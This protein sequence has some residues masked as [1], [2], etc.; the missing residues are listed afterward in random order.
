MAKTR[1]DSDSQPEQFC[2]PDDLSQAILDARANSPYESDVFGDVSEPGV[3]HLIRLAYYASQTPNEARFPR[4]S[5]FVPSAKQQIN[6]LISL[7]EELRS[8]SL[9][10]IAPVLASSDHTLVVQ[11]CDQSLHISGI[12]ALRGQ[13]TELSLGDPTS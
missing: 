6:F 13:L 12:A 5:L 2:G 1:P 4:L 3:I 9:R 10:R 11:Q 8:S 7:D